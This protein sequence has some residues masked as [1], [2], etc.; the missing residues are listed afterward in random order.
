MRE[1]KVSE[2]GDEVSEHKFGGNKKPLEGERALNN[3][4]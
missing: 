4:Y 3:T 1:L 2:R